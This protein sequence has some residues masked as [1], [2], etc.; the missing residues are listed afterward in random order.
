M[1]KADTERIRELCSLIATEKDRH[2]FQALVEKLNR[3]LEAMV[4]MLPVLPLNTAAILTNA[5]PQ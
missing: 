1:N 4:S 3:I 2:K 5:Q